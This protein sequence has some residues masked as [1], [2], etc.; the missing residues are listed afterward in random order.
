VVCTIGL[1]GYVTT[2]AECA[3]GN[4]KLPLMRVPQ[5]ARRQIRE[6]SLEFSVRPVAQGKL[7]A[8]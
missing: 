3:S 4:L 1:A 5:G 6:Q 7:K 2:Y 8:R